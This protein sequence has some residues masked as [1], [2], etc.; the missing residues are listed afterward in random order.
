MIG[1]FY[2][3][4]PEMS[5]KMRKAKLTKHEM[6]L[7]L[8]L[9]EKDLSDTGVVKLSFTPN[10]IQ[11]LGISKATYYR[12]ISRLQ[13]AGVLP[14]GII[15][16]KAEYSDSEHQIR[17]RLHTELGGQ[18]EVVTAVGRIDVLTDS[19]LIEIK[20]IR[21]WKNALGQILAYAAFFPEHSKRIH[22]FGK[23]DLARLATCQTTCS[24][25]GISV[26]FEEVQ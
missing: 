22:L 4:T 18:V 10:L 19:E 23:A 26:T 15:F 8:Y 21:D 1:K 17:D 25:F 11:E 12:V 9:V 3:L 13:N 7:W 2:P 5:N 14:E 24:E 20:D 16:N 6:T